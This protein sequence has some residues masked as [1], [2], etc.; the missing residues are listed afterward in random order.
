MLLEDAADRLAEALASA[1]ALQTLR[2]NGNKLGDAAAAAF[3]AALK[4]PNLAL[5][6]LWL[7]SPLL[8]GAAKVAL[9]SEWA[10][11]GRDPERLHL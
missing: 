1:P 4:H 7:S 11:S 9:Q 6:E 3:G 8:S 5:D 10:E 2:L